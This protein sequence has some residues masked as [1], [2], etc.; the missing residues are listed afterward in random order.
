MKKVLLTTLAI[1][2]MGISC[3]EK[4][5][6][7]KLTDSGL[8]PKNFQT[9]VDGKKTDLYVL[10]NTVGME[11]CV[12]NYGGRI[13]SIM[14][15]D[16]DG[17]KKDV[18]LGFDSIQDY[19]SVAGNNYGAVIGRYGNR[20]GNATIELDGIKYQLPQNNFG[21]TLHGGDKGFHTVVFDAKQID[22]KILELTY[23]SKDGEEGFPGNLNCK[24]TYILN[25]NN[26]IHIQYEAETDKT[27]VVNLTNHSYFNMDGDPNETNAHWIMKINADNFTPVDSTFMTTGEILAVEGTDMDFRTPTAVGERI[28]NFGY[29]QLKNGMGYDHNWVLNTKGDIKQVAASVES[30]KTGIVLEVYTTEPGMQFYAGNFMDGSH[31][32]KKGI[33]YKHRTAVCLE[34]QKYPDTPNKPD[35]PSATLK[36]GEKYTSETIYKFSVKK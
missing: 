17:N 26:E 15:P 4:A 35:W 9:E 20:I 13:V 16:K 11:V 18:A 8:N 28:D 22:D 5:P 21:H 36:P 2:L 7:E 24:V 19:I 3:T 27:T 31:A 25:D 30:P 29:D 34:T 6:V 14:V 33:V 1:S 32:G 23:L 12:T 10:T